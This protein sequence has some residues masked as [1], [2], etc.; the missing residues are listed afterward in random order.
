MLCAVEAPYWEQDGLPPSMWT[1]RGFG[2]LCA[3]PFGANGEITSAAFWMMGADALAAD[4]LSDAALTERCLQEL[5]ALRPR[6]ADALRPLRV[7]SWQRAAT[8]MLL[9]VL[10]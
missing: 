7:I 4:R 6:A 9:Q 5:R 1:D 3:Y 2:Q 10:G 8:A